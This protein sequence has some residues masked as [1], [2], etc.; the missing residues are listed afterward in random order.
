MAFTF[1]ND[2]NMTERQDGID[3]LEPDCVQILTPAFIA[4]WPWAIT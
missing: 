4:L 1:K 2:L 3:T